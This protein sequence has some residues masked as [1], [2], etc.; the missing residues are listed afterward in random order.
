MTDIFDYVA[1]QYGQ[2]GLAQKVL[3]ALAGE[4]IDID[5]LK[6]ADLANVDQFHTRGM[7]ATR[8][9]G[10][11][12]APEAG[13]TVLDIGCG[14][15][16]PA[17]FL[18]ETYG[19]RVSGVD[20][21]PDYIEVA[22]VLSER[23]RMTDVT[24]FCV[25]NALDLPFDNGAFDLVWTQNVSMNIEDKA[26]FYGEICRVLKPGGRLASAEVARGTA[27]PTYPLPW[28]REPAI[29]FSC[30][31]ADMR[32]AIEGAGLEV[33]EWRDNTAE[34]VAVF[35]NP[36]QQAR[37]GKLGVPLIAGADFPQRSNNLAQGMADGAFV[38]LM[39]AAEKPG[40]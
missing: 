33:T 19:C 15:G 28:A 26:A 17:R 31:A 23:C 14:V 12:A 18:A 6:T 9:Q 30:S 1:R 24:D 35:Q 3:D 16:G 34:A 37:R 38:N 7:A 20:L 13:M 4:G 11:L 2:Q 25:A 36:S 5:N 10:D 40:V 29:D 39:F 22:R 27:P 8:E 21:T 32:A